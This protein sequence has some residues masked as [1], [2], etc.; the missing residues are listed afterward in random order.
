MAAGAR[1]PAVAGD[2]RFAG[3]LKLVPAVLARPVIEKILR[4]LGLEPQ[5]SPSAPAR[6]PPPRRAG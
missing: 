2:R 1:P 5:P 4:H 3:E 6:Q